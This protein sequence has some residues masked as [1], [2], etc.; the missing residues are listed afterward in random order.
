MN[1]LYPLLLEHNLPAAARCC[2]TTA[3]MLVCATLQACLQML[4]GYPGFFLLL[5]RVFV[6]GL[7]CDR[8]SGILAARIAV[9]PGAHLSFKGS[10]EL[11]Y[12]C[13]NSLFATTA[14]G[15]AV[16][17]EFLR[18]EMKRV[19]QANKGPAA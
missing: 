5:P 6:S 13:A 1:K 18:S 14:A 8:G 9:L 15:S 16:V 10:I 11:E 2:I 3:I 4:T 17:A 12:F 7:V 19:M